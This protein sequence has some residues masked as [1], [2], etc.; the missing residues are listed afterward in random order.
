MTGRQ[1]GTGKAHSR[2]VLI[3]VRPGEPEHRT[4]FSGLGRYQGPLFSPDG[5]RVQVGWREAGQWIF[6][7]TSRDADPIA[8]DNIARQFE[9]EGGSGQPPPRIESWCCR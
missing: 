4:V 6:V 8:V 1:E 5:S 9:S 2:L 3:G 7:P